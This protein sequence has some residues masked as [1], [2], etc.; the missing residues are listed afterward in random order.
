MT[1]TRTEQRR[2]KAA[3]V[4]APVGAPAMD[5]IKRILV[6]L[7]APARSTAKLA[8]AGNVSEGIRIALAHWLKSQ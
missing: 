8:G 4:A 3:G 5:D 7:D 2:R 1:S 6:S